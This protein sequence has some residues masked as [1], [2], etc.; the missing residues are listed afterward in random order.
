MEQKQNQEKNRKW[1]MTKIQKIRTLKDIKI[2]MKKGKYTGNNRN[3]MKPGN[4]NEIKMMKKV[5]EL[6]GEEG[7]ETGEPQ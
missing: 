3:L 5:V 7:G 6:N 1:N 4:K 2:Y